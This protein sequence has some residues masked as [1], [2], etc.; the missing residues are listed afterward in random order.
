[1]NKTLAISGLLLATA[2]VSCQKHAGKPQEMEAE[3]VTVA[4][5]EVKDI[6]LS[7]T[8]PGTL[9][10]NNVVDVMCKVNGQVLSRTFTKGTEV[11]KGQVLYTIDPT[12]YRDKVEQAQAALATA[13]STRDYAASHYAAVKKALESDAV[14]RMEVNQAES[15]LQQAEAAIKNATAAL[16]QA[17]ISLNDCTITAPIT[18]RIAEGL[19]NVGAFISGEGAPVKVT[20][21]YDNSVME[22][23]FAIED[24]RFLD[25]IN[26]RGGADSLDFD[27]IPVSFAEPLPRSYT[28]KVTYL[29]PA[30]N[31][32]T[33]T[34]KMNCL[35]DNP[36]DDLRQGMYVKIDL[37]YGRMRNAVLVKDSS[38]GSDQLGKYLY[39]VSDSG[40]VVYT[41]VT[42]GEL[43][44]DSLRV[45]TGGLASDARYITRAM[46]KVKEGMK[47]NAVTAK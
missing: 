32:A 23:E 13:I 36:D 9:L 5:P 7:K 29:A 31:E 3:T 1:M 26:S 19:F 43:Y 44:H 20:T 22:A 37:P 2:L 21:L 42:L 8:Y 25:I 35:I 16:Q 38:I 28:G 39:T 4:L 10:A 41:P 46:L 6:V 14:S 47:V 17:R 27:H 34:L 30:L 33:G 18:G 11:K 40:R 15:A 45:I 12:T 24:E